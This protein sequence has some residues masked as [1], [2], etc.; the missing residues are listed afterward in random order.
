MKKLI[1]LFILL[2]TSFSVFAQTLDVDPQN[3][4][5]E[6]G[7]I[8]L[9]NS[10]SSYNP[11]HID[12]YAGH[13]R[14]F[15]SGTTYFQ[16]TPSGETR[17]P[18]DFILNN[19][20]KVS[21][22]NNFASEGSISE[23]VWGNYILTN[24]LTSRTLRIGVSND[25]YTRGEIEIEN[26]DSASA[27]IFFKT[28]NAGGGANARMTILGDG[29]IG[30]GTTNPY[31]L[32]DVRTSDN[33]GLRF[34]YNDESAITFWP[35]NGNSVFHLS[36]GHDNK[37]YL[38]H[39]SNVGATKLMTFVNSSRVGIGT[40]SPTDMLEIAGNLKING[41]QTDDE[42]RF[43]SQNG[44]HRIAFRQLRFYDWDGGGDNL[45]I[46]NGT[47]GIGTTDTKGFKL[48]VNGKI[49]A[50]EVKVATYSNWADF[51]FEKN[52]NLPTLKEVEEHI[53]ENGHLKDIPSAKEVKK[54]GFFL[55]DMDSKLLQKIEELTLY[56]IEQQKE[57]QNQ[58][59]I[60]EALEERLK[61]NEKLLYSKKQ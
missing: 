54:D 23:G 32:L 50:T 31:S 35:N 11:W 30:I 3:S 6:G 34:N 56:T 5:V 52:Y 38:S 61:K 53:K 27:K 58:K 55:G 1:L 46:N 42:I 22:E 18:N 47:V 19:A 36:H 37:L 7:E 33:K 39:G 60:N 45:T 20:L 57:L 16:V 44:F 13:F 40:T 21:T 17:V 14:L 8:R 59:V 48:G 10:N 26:N 49:A 51:V 28:S 2:I 9:L 25:S 29:K 15:H 43:E 12:N 4:G 24:N 41:S